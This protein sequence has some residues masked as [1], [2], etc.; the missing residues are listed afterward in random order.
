MKPK[1]DV[2]RGTLWAAATLMASL[3]LSMP[4]SASLIGDE[5][6]GSAS[7]S[8]FDFDSNTATVGGGIEFIAVLANATIIADFDGDSVTLSY[9]NTSNFPNITFS[10]TTFSFTDLDWVGVAGTITGLT[11]LANDFPGAAGFATSFTADSIQIDVPLTNT[12]PNDL[13]TATYRIDTRHA[14]T[15]EPATA[16]L[17]VLGLAAAS[18]SRRR[19]S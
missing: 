18:R 7:G 17:L 6:M 11:E 16:A 13:F 19:H 9:E 8:G 10:A 3:A 12:N 2:T 4:A 5:I 15:P 1:R 14:T